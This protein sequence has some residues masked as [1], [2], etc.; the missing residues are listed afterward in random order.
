M[1]EKE[2]RPGKRRK[3]SLITGCGEEEGVCPDQAKTTNSKFPSDASSKEIKGGDHKVPSDG[4][5]DERFSDT[6]VVEHRNIGGHP[7]NFL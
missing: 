7:V 1:G 2:Q 5:K 6:P 3:Y 4:Q